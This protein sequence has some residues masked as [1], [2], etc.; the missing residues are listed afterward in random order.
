MKNVLKLALLAGL[1]S[2][3]TFAFAAGD[4]I[5]ERKAMMKSVGAAAG[6]SG[7]M[8]KGQTEFD[9]RVA[10]LALRTMNAVALGYGSKFP[11]GSDSG[12]TKAA[13]SIWSDPDGYAAAIAKFEADTAAALSAP[14]ADLDA[15]K[16]QFGMVA[17]NCGAC[18]QTYRN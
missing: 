4:P 12:D 11:D 17:A 16:A 18:H 6:A 2:A 8:M 13:A 5:A 15:F 10:M 7:A 14:A 9:P 1:A 3:S